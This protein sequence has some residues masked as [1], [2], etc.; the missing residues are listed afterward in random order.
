MEG[1]FMMAQ[2]MVVN[3]IPMFQTPVPMFPMQP[4]TMGSMTQFPQYHQGSFHS[5]TPV[6]MV[7]FID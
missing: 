4:M 2:P 7:K 6:A 3:P 5:M 1:P